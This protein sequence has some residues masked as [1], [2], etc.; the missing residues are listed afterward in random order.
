[1]LRTS[2]L[3]SIKDAEERDFKPPNTK[4]TYETAVLE[5]RDFPEPFGMT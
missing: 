4:I 5:T 2:D 3:T 1:M